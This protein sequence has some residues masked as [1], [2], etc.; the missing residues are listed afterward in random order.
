VP[1]RS[2]RDRTDEPR[3]PFAR[4]D[5]CATPRAIFPHNMLL[6]SPRSYSLVGFD[7]PVRFVDRARMERRECGGATLDLA[8]ASPSKATI[9]S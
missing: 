5:F 1:R 7:A 9:S 4:A 2:K 8:I 3:P 6:N